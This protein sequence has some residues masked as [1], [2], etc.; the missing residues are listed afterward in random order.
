MTRIDRLITSIRAMGVCDDSVLAAMAAVP[1]HHFVP[2]E[3]RSFAWDDHPLPIGCDQ[4]ISQPLVVAYMTWKLEVLPTHR[5]LEIGTGSGYQAAVLARL[6]CQVYTVE[7]RE[8]LRATAR[9]CFIQ[10]GLV[11]IDSRLG[12]GTRGW[13][14]AAPFDRIIVTAAAESGEPPPPL[15]EQLKVGGMMIIPLG[16]G[17]GGQRLVRIRRDETGFQREALWSVRFVPLVA[18]V[19]GGP[20]ESPAA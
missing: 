18:D 1:R 14:E 2:P 17:R 7:R 11:G 15:L 3:L 4:T 5:V 9:K 20:G 12:D 16:D 19:P 6:G 8:P 13:P 10:Q